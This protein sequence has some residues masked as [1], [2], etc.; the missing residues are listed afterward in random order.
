MNSQSKTS[1]TYSIIAALTF[2]MGLVPFFLNFV[3]DP[4]EINS[5]ID[6]DIEKAKISEKSHYPLWKIIHY[7]AEASEVV[8]LGDSRARALKE[9]FWHQLGLTNTYNFAY[10]GATIY[11]L[12]D[13]FHYIKNSPN[14]K[15][16]VVGIQLRSFDPNHKG[17]M[18]RV[19]EA[20]RL[21]SNLLD[22]YTN[23]FVSRIS[24]KL[25]EEKYAAQY[26]AIS[27]MNLSAVSS[28][29]A[30]PVDQKDQHAYLELI[31]EEICKNC[32]LPS[33][34][35]PSPYIVRNGKHAYYFGDALGVWGRLWP[36][37]ASH[38][39]LE[40]RFKTQ[41]NKNARSDWNKFQ[42][43]EKL[44]SQIV[45]I[46]EWT[47]KHNVQLIFVIPPTIVEM[48]QRIVDFGLGELNH[49]FRIRLANLA[50]V[51]D[52]DFI[53][54]ITRDINNFTDAYHFNYVAAKQ[55]I[56]EVSLRI[57]KDNEVLK[58]AFKRRK[59]ITCPLSIDEAQ[60]TIRDNNIEVLEGRA[61]RIWRKRHDK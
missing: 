27:Q 41:V 15:T 38:Q 17:G 50:P 22:Y 28:A 33:N 18:N 59:Q 51:M 42:F 34:I 6:L 23:W 58:R 29:G 45:E 3:V 61:C 54:P 52:F 48:Q 21:S 7:P 44:W 60:T 10:G 53:N 47:D 46:S 2:M 11:E 39:I 5:V 9:K 37:I 56:G 36:P 8:V 13:T 20:I 49:K 43:S 12:S 55:I 25:L 31:D 26:S 40:G 32:K 4:Y 24:T 30:A 19:P 35:A 1:R 57:T 16:L 14:L